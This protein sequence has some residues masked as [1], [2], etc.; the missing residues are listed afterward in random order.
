MKEE[1]TK[2]SQEEAENCL[3][4]AEAGATLALRQ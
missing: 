1:A 3:L 2:R 4:V